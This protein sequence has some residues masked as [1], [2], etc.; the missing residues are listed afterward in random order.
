VF[1]ILRDLQNY[2]QS[3]NMQQVE[4]ARV[5]S[6]LRG[7]IIVWGVTVACI[8]GIIDVIWLGI[9]YLIYLIRT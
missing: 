8:L 2:A 9:Y 6:R 7:Q 4:E 3:L 1:V 5:R